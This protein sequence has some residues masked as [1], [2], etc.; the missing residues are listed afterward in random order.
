M[1]S[2]AARDVPLRYPVL[3]GTFTLLFVLRVV[4]QALVGL[5]EAS[6][7][8]PFERWYSGLLPYSLLLPA[9]IALIVLMLKIVADFARGN[10]Y[11]VRL[12]RA[13]ASSCRCSPASM[14]SPWWCATS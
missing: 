3:L 14:P 6:F 7:L 13:R 12:S 1:P 10:G 4:G 2:Q 11:F 9:Q 5:G 8:P